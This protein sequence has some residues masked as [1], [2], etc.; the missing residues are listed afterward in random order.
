MLGDLR[1][2]QHSY[3]RREFMPFGVGLQRGIE[4]RLKAPQALVLAVTPQQPRK[5]KQICKQLK[6]FREKTYV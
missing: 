1:M 2:D 4:P 5:H 3:P 6:G